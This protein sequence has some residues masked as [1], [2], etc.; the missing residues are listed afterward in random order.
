MPGLKTF[1]KLHKTNGFNYDLQRAMTCGNFF[2][3]VFHRHR[4]K[5]LLSKLDYTNKKVLEVGC[6]TGI[7]L[8]ALAEKGVNIVGID[9]VKSDIKTAR[10]YLKERKLSESLVKVGDARNL[11]YKDNSFDIVLLSDLLEHVSNTK[12]AAQEAIRVIKPNGHILITVPNHL[13]PVVRYPWLKKALTGRKNFDEFP[14]V[15]FSFQKLSMLFPKMRLV[16]RKLVY[17]LSD[18]MAIY[19]KPSC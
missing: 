6:N 10:K 5:I 15:P 18:I 3:K 2:E 12:K 13:H 19:Q 16:E 8:I 17:F 14:D 9:I 1:G 7:L 11:P 4:L